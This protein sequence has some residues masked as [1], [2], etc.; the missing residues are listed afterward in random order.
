MF[1]NIVHKKNETLELLQ[2]FEDMCSTDTSD[3]LKPLAVNYAT[4][5][6][7]GGTVTDMVSP[8]LAYLILFLVNFVH[9]RRPPVLLPPESIH[10]SLCGGL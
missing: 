1:S 10:G 9:D 3:P 2:A 6:Q 8:I 7:K 4:F 5:M